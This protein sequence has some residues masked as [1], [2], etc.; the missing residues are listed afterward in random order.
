MKRHWTRE[1]MHTALKTNSLGAEVSY[2]DREDNKSNP[3][4]W[5]V[6]MPLNAPV[7]LRADNRVHLRTMTVQIVHLHRLKLD[8]IADLMLE[9]FAVEPNYSATPK[10]TQTDY[11]S[12]YYE[13]Q[14]FTGGGW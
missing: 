7:A 13:V 10:D 4:N 9:T 6:Y 1:E 11:W 14:I 3:D 8:S 5:I 2:L 12:T